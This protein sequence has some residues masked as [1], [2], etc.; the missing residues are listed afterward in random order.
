MANAGLAWV[1]HLADSNALLATNS[2]VTTLPLANVKDLHGA[3]LWRSLSATGVYVTADLGVAQPVEALAV[4]CANFSAA[5]TWRLRLS[6][7]GAHSGD[8]YDSG[9]VAMNRALVAKVRAQAVLLLPAAIN[10]RYVRIDFDDSGRAAEGNFDVG[11]LWLS[12]FW[13]PERNFSYGAQSIMIDASTT[14]P[15]IGGQ[16]YT[17]IRNKIRAERFEFNA[18]REAELYNQVDQIDAIAGTSGNILFVPDPGGTYQNRKMI[19][20]HLTELGASELSSFP[21]RAKA[22]EIKE[23][24]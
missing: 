18:L 4:A 14:T 6:S 21:V 24:I 11:I 10:A 22:F 23:R 3:S 15:S 19:I 17:D 20:G 7:T 16:D 13:Q 8:L 9:V 12:D 1:N 5:A 2:E